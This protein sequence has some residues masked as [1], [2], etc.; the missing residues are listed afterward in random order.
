MRYVRMSMKRI[1]H[2]WLLSLELRIPLWTNDKELIKVLKEKGLIEL[3][4]LEDLI[5]N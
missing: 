1:H 4:T 5:H 2:L 3:V